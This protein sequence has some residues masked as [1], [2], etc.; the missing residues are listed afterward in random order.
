MVDSGG[1]DG[2]GA[3]IAASSSSSSPNTYTH[4]PSV[5]RLG[6]ESHSGRYLEVVVYA[7]LYEHVHRR[8]IIM[9]L[10]RISVWRSSG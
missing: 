1:V 9:E 3:I 6:K 4:T 8:Y 2:G 5:L 10:A 7:E